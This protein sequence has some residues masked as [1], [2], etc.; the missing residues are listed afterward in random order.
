MWTRS[1]VLQENQQE[2][3]EIIWLIQ[4]ESGVCSEFF[5]I[6]PF[7]PLA[8]FYFVFILF[9]WEC[10]PD[11]LNFGEVEMELF[12]P[13]LFKLPS[14]SSH[15]RSSEVPSSLVERVLV[16][17]SQLHSVLGVTTLVSDGSPGDR[18]V[19]VGFFVWFVNVSPYV[20]VYSLARSLTVAPESLRLGFYIL[21]VGVKVLPWGG[22]GTKR[23]ELRARLLAQPTA[24]PPSGWERAELCV[25]RWVNRTFS[26]R[27]C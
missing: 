23:A 14:S 13:L 8:S 11:H 19:L 7:W 5:N 1:A 3:F 2:V 27:F 24:V 17:K 6:L 10:L 4:K 20:P 15:S 18:G 12:R 25:A 9:W 16:V 22:S 21:E 26:S